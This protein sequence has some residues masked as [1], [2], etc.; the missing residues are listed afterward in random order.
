MMSFMVVP[1]AWRKK[2]LLNSSNETWFAVDL[3]ADHS[4]RQQSVMVV[5]ITRAT[6][7]AATDLGEF[8]MGAVTDATASVMNA[9]VVGKLL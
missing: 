2:L 3:T 1:C 6:V 8:A 5:A 4:V 9:T 7:V